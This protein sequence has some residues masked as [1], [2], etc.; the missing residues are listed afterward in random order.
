[1][2]SPESVQALW[3]HVRAQYPE[4]TEPTVVLAMRRLA[5]VWK[6]LF[7]AEQMRLVNL[8]IERVVLLSDGIDIV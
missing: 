7:R 3:N 2:Q 4:T 1:M 6:A 5:E 8:L